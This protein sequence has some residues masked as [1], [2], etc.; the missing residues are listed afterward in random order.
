MSVEAH[1]V[2]QIILQILS[3]HIF[4]TI[5]TVLMKGV[6]NI[7][8]H[9]DFCFYLNEKGEACI[10]NYLGSDSELR[11][12]EMLDGHTVTQIIMRAFKNEKKI[13]TLFIPETVEV[14][15]DEAFVGC[16]NLEEIIVDKNNKYYCDLNGILYTKNKQVEVRMPPKYNKGTVVTEPMETVKM[17]NHVMENNKT[18]SQIIMSDYITKIGIHAFYNSK[19]QKI[20]IS[21]N[22]K[23]IDFCTF[24]GCKNLEEVEIRGNKLEEIQM[25]AFAGCG[26]LKT[27]TIPDSCR[28]IGHQA[29]AGCR[30][31]SRDCRSLRELIIPDSCDAIEKSAFRGCLSLRKITLPK[32][33]EILDEW[34]FKGCKALKIIEIPDGVEEINDNAFDGCDSLKLITIPDS[35][36]SIKVWEN[37][38][39]LKKT[40]IKCNPGSYAEEWAKAYGIRTKPIASALDKLLESDD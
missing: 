37:H 39:N 22:V 4:H 32:S 40:I 28:I 31:L 24:N 1:G 10:E 17:E 18:V 19:L 29:F 23:R 35:V 21:R 16:V 7:L 13:K 2:T 25:G 15:S 26:A 38:I 5:S 27:I 34:V 36:L 20:S 8:E 12:P 9:G 30:S 3:N 11:I 33:L 14:I 6:K